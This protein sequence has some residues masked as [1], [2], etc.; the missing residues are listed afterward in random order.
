MI[1]GIVGI[2]VA[3]V[4][5]DWFIPFIYNVGLR[6][7]RSSALA[8]LFLGGLVALEQIFKNNQS[9]ST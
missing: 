1:G 3:A 6:G 5:G 4:L 8:W 2:L 7:F 9:P